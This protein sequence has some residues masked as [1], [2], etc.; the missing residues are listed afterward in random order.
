M[1]ALCDCPPWLDFAEEG[2]ICWGRAR[3]GRGMFRFGW[4]GGFALSCGLKSSPPGAP[5]TGLGRGD[6][7]S[8]KDRC[9]PSLTASP[10]QNRLRVARNHARHRR[11]G[12]LG[13]LRARLL[14]PP[15][16]STIAA[17]GLCGHL[18]WPPSVSP[19]DRG[20]WKPRLGRRRARVA[21]RPT[22]GV[23]HRREAGEGCRPSARG[24]EELLLSIFL[25]C[26]RIPRARS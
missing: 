11:P 25:C 2:S 8:P 5:N 16:A 24:E 19:E 22:V 9:R 1:P 15:R 3:F 13:L 12:S 14:A 17:T 23:G 26:V 4:P 20:R 21:A 10:P 6:L 18:G 7:F